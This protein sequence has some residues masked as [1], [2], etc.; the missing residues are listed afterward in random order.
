M[1]NIKDVYVMQFAN[2]DLHNLFMLNYESA[3]IGSAFNFVMYSNVVLNNMEF[4]KFI[5]AFGDQFIL[6]LTRSPCYEF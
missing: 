5:T 6:S 1:T 3:R 2:R 4:F